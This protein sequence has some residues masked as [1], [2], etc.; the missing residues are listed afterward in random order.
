MAIAT[1]APVY[2]RISFTQ[3]S[4][5][6]GRALMYYRSQADK[7]PP[8]ISLIQGS[9]VH[10]GIEH[11]LLHGDREAAL[12]FAAEELNYRVEEAGGVDSVTWDDPPRFTKPNRDFEYGRP[13][14]GDEGNMPDLETA[15]TITRHM[16]AAWIERFPALRVSDRSRL[17]QRERIPLWD[18]WELTVVYD[19]RPDE[20]G[21]IDIKVSR[22]AWDITGKH[23]D[24]LEQAFLYQYGELLRTGELPEF[25]VFH[26]LPRSGVRWQVIPPP[27]PPGYDYD[28]P[29]PP[30]GKPSLEIFGYRPD[31]IQVIDV[32][33]NPNEVD[34]ILEFKVR[35]RLEA[36][37]A[38]IYVPNTEGWWCSETFC[39]YWSIC[40]LGAARRQSRETAQSQP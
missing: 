10:A 18:G 13:Y 25:F 9:A 31:A 26:N 11:H 17:E 29:S 1:T 15:H 4:Q 39:D 8:D 16:T 36:I 2:R 33:Y 28:D 40:P 38:G 7:G 5:H 24:K 35:P 27:E 12:S 21:M 6:C 19:V 23:F 20:G 30:E 32:A 14:K 34:A 37:E 3:I 22:D